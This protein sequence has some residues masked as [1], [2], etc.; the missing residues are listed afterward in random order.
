MYFLKLLTPA[1]HVHCR[2]ARWQAVVAGLVAVRHG[3]QLQLQLQ[4]DRIDVPQE[5]PLE[6]DRYGAPYHLTLPAQNR[7]MD[8][9]AADSPDAY[10]QLVELAV[11][12]IVQYAAEQHQ[13]RHLPGAAPSRAAIRLQLHYQAPQGG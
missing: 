6:F 10:G 7:L 3:R 2:P 11:D 1:I 13:L 9:L 4:Q 5:P 8:M 12:I